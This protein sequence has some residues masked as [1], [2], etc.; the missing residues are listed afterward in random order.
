MKK[1]EVC[2]NMTKPSLLASNLEY[3]MTSLPQKLRTTPIIN[4]AIPGS[5]DSMTY[6]ITKDSEVSPDA[7]P[8]LQQLKFLGPI[9]TTFMERWSKTQAAS[10]TQ[11]LKLGIRYFDLRIATKPNEDKFYFVHGLYSGEVGGIL[12]EIKAFLD[13]HP[14]E[15]VILDCQH[16]YA[17]EQADHERLMQLLTS[18]FGHKL[19]PYMSHMDHITLQYMTNECR[20]QV[21]VVYRSDAARFGQPLLWP[22]GC[23]PTPWANTDSIPELIAFLSDML[24]QRDP[25]MGYISQCVL[26]PSSCFV[27]THLY[28]ERPVF[29]AA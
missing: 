14:F 28:F 25:L 24:K 29:F 4:L 3:W 22:S 18:V 5:H 12:D 9:L 16:F 6:G 15:V 19:L 17:F 8:I 23:F 1:H 27:V 13:T 7:E 11:Q 26:T 20:Y 10:A 2:L 21:I